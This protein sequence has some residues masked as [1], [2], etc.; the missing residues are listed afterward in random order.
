[1]WTQDQAAYSVPSDL[2]IY[3]LSAIEKVI[4]AILLSS[5]QGGPTGV[6]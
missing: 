5:S 6:N 4:P 3:R 1:M 2:D